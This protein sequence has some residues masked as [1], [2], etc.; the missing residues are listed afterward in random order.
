[1]S[2]AKIDSFGHKTINIGKYTIDN[3]AILANFST[4][5]N[6]ILGLYAFIAVLFPDL[7]YTDHY[8]VA[9]FIVLGASFDAIDGKLARRSNTAP[10]LGAQFDTAADLFTFGLSPTAIILTMFYPTSAVIAYLFALVYLFFASFRLSRFMIDPTTKSTGYFRGMPSPPAAIFIA[11]W[12]VIADPNL[13]IAAVLILFVAGTMITNY[14]FTAM[15]SVKTKFQKINFIF[16]VSIMLLFTYAPDTWMQSIGYIWIAQVTYF[17]IGG[18][19]HAYL[20]LDVEDD[21]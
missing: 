20:T 1:M 10:R 11:G 21:S 4:V 19:F 15:K 13:V 12:Y 7:L 6:L 8:I 18:P 3:Y 17:A 16:T 9:R 2:I 14:P 5:S